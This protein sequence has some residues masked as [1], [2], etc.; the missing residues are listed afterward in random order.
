MKKLVLSVVLVNLLSACVTNKAPESAPASKQPVAET[1]AAPIVAEAQPAQTNTSAVATEPSAPGSAPQ[2]QVSA[3]AVA[4]EATQT[5]A[6]QKGT[7]PV[8]VRGALVDQSVTPTQQAN[9]AQPSAPAAPETQSSD[10]AAINVK[11]VHFAFDSDSVQDAD[12]AVVQAHGAFLSLNSAQ[13]VR[14]EGHADERGSSEYNLA[15][16]QR[17]ASSTKKAL[18][19]A[20]AKS[21]QIE[22]VSF[23][24]EKPLDA[25]HDEAAWAQNRRS[26]IIYK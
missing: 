9:V 1:P 3:S 5:A 24:E 23:G 22:T 2:A 19:L 6:T 21:S 10:N 18:T 13:K 20:G 26:E 14:V 25:G 11:L 4:P 17:R 15:L 7:A 8:G 16:G 12:K